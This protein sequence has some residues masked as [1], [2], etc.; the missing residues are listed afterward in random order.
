MRVVSVNVGRPRDIVWQGKP[1]VTSIFKS[2]VGGRV[3]VRF[4]NIDGDEQSDLTVHGGIDKAVYGYPSEHYEFWRRELDDSELP[5]GV[6]G[7]NLTTEG[8]DERSLSVGDVFR[9]GSTQLMVSQPRLP[10]YKLA[11]RFGRPDMVKR[12]LASR[13]VGYYFAVVVE[14]E[15]AAGDSIELLDAATER[16]T[17]EELVGLYATKSPDPEVMRRALRLRGLAEVW[18]TELTQ[19]LGSAA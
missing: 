7:E 5:W 19:L 10:C 14:G 18:R 16:M 12:F 9:V 1:V 8:L 4:L 13:R 15:V 3:A 17:V 6:F 11:A 2:P